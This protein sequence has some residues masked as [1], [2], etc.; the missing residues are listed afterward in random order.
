MNERDEFPVFESVIAWA[1]NILAGVGVVATV[2]AAALLY[3]G[4]WK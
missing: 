3:A 2:I 4:F 1:S